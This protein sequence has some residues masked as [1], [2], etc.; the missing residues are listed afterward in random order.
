MCN[1]WLSLRVLGSKYISNSKHINQLEHFQKI[2]IELLD[3]ISFFISKY[4]MENEK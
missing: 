3:V 2:D 4:L 1:S